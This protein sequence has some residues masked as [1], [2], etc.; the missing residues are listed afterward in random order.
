MRKIKPALGIVLLMLMPLILSVA[1]AQED[2]LSAIKRVRQDAKNTP[3]N[4][5]NMDERLAIVFQWQRLLFE[6]G[7]DVSKAVTKERAMK[8]DS[9]AKTTPKEAFKMIDKAYADLERNFGKVELTMRHDPLPGPPQPPS[10][11]VPYPPPANQP[12]TVAPPMGG[13]HSPPTATRFDAQTLKAV[14]AEVKASPTTEQNVQYR[15]AALQYWAG[16]LKTLNPES[17]K[18]FPNET[19]I[20]IRAYLHEDPK[21]AALIVDRVFGDLERLDSGAKPA[22]PKDDMAKKT[23]EL[24]VGTHIDKG[25]SDP[26]RKVKITEAVPAS[27]SGRQVAGYSSAFKSYTADVKNGVV[28]IDVTDTPLYVEPLSE[29]RC[30]ANPVESPFVLISPEIDVL[31]NRNSE[32]YVGKYSAELGLK[33]IRFLGATGLNFMVYKYGGKDFSS[34]GG[35]LGQI[36]ALYGD[37]VSKGLNVI[38][39]IHPGTASGPNPQAGGVGRLSFAEKDV[40][41]Y[42]DFL[43]TAVAKLPKVKYFFVETEADYKFDPKDYALA[44]STTYK[45]I[46]AACPDCKIITAGYV[47][48]ERAYYKEVLDALA[49]MKVD[50]AFDIYG[51]W[52]PFG[53]LNVYKGNDT[54]YEKIRSEF[55]KSTRLLKA[56]GYEGVPIWIGE[57]SYPSGSHNPYDTGFSERKQAAGL[58]ERYTTA[59]AAGVKKI[60]WTNI[61]DHNKFAG[62]YS[63]YDYAGLINNPKNA[64]AS[65]KKLSYYTYMMLIEKFKCLDSPTVTR[66][67]SK[68]GIDGYKL[69][70]KNGQ[71]LYVLWP[72]AR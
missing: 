20:L 8:I 46:K 41:D 58:V 34:G 53:T 22:T 32:K 42:T 62:D 16:T 35:Y 5:A 45:T 65:Y 54:E 10:Q 12:P 25:V 64:G 18:I 47:N 68:K 15:A 21:K 36:E 11:G 37:A 57:T 67:A 60:I 56:Y 4:A 6:Q 14:R 59:I 17:Q 33:W 23:V 2:L 27:Q 55:D 44:L 49:L 51:M 43:R 61:Y 29:A 13:P 3:T 63:Y 26:W 30:T 31:L 19:S 40:K 24:T 48:P 66:M 70:G 69:E 9:T 39:T 28:E 50:R 52:H 71:T 7:I 72:D 38:A 1:L